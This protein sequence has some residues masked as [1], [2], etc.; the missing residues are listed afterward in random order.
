MVRF[1]LTIYPYS[2]G[3]TDQTGTSSVT[4]GK[5]TYGALQ[6]DQR[7]PVAHPVDY[8]IGWAGW[9]AVQN[10]ANTQDNTTLF[11]ANAPRRFITVPRDLARVV[12]SNP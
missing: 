10:G 2:L 6:I 11:D 8:M 4:D 9:L 3:T 7:V 5:I 1:A 12:F